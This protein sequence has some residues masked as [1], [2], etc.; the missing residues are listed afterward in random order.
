MAW[1]G[2]TAALLGPLQ[3][4]RAVELAE[5][6]VGFD[7]PKLRKTAAEMPMQ[8]GAAVPPGEVMIEI[9]DL[10]DPAHPK[11]LSCINPERLPGGKDGLVIDDTEAYAAIGQYKWWTKSCAK[12]GLPEI[13]FSRT[14]LLGKWVA[15]GGCSVDFKRRAYL[16]EPNKTVHYNIEVTSEGSCEMMSSSMNWIAVPKIPPGYQVKFY[17]GR[18][19]ADVRVEDEA[20]LPTPE[21]ATSCIEDAVGRGMDAPEAIGFCHGR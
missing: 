3:P 19:R 20:A 16:D 8:A 7:M 12:F 13:D 9:E 21:R 18:R 6:R 14:T 1:F 11:N 2:I 15:A 10:N 4:E 5:F 17:V